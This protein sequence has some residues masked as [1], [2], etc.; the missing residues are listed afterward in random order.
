MHRKTNYAG[1]QRGASVEEMREFFTFYG[2]VLIPQGRRLAEES[3]VFVYFSPQMKAI[4][5]GDIFYSTGIG[6]CPIQFI[7]NAQLHLDTT[8]NV[9]SI[10]DF[11]KQV[12]LA[13]YSAFVDPRTDSP[14]IEQINVFTTK[15]ETEIRELLGKVSSPKGRLSREADSPISLEDGEII[16]LFKEDALRLLVDDMFRKVDESGSKSLKAFSLILER[17][18]IYSSLLRLKNLGTPAILDGLL[19]ERI[20]DSLSAAFGQRIFFAD[21]PGQLRLSPITYVFGGAV[22][23]YSSRNPHFLIS[24]MLNH[25]IS[26]ALEEE[27]PY[28]YAME[29]LLST[30]NLGL[31]D[32]GDV[33]VSA[34]NK[35]V[36]K[37]VYASLEEIR[38]AAH[39]ALWGLC[40]I[41]GQ[42]DGKILPIL[43]NALSEARKLVF[44]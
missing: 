2:E 22:S 41:S 31:F 29:T 39:E 20:F 12:P 32:D 30:I 5:S 6:G 14:P 40:E 8:T 7:T 15:A 37:Y 24:R 34:L 10:T 26:Y 4:L 27:T 44:G 16:P 9:I 3:Q 19:E 1:A 43:E 23:L 13:E 35:T 21:S 11:L 36:P 25:A 18:S 42:D 33:S 38:E 17:Y 28:G